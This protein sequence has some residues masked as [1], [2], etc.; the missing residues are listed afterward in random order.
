MR[1]NKHHW[2]GAVR[3]H[4]SDVGTQLRPTLSRH[5]DIQEDEVEVSLFQHA[6]GFNWITHAHRPKV[7]SCDRGTDSLPRNDFVIYDQDL[8]WSGHLSSGFGCVV[9]GGT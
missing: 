9:E 5:F 1:G 7:G 4:L 8:R 3:G 2:C 6:L